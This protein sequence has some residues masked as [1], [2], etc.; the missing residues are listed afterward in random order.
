MYRFQVEKMSCG[1]CASRVTKAIQNVDDA[2]QVDIDLKSKQ[3]R[4][5][6]SADVNLLAAAIAGAGYP[7]QI[8]AGAAA[9]NR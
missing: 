9:E 8:H 4:V 1:G 2:A 5:E 3:V 6:S 7:V